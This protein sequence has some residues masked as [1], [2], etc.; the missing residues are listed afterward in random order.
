MDAYEITWDDSNQTIAETVMWAADENKPLTIT[1]A[2][3]GT[4]HYTPKPPPA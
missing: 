4:V 2:D 1:T 3:G